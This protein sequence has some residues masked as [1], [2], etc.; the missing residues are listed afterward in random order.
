M[1]LKSMRDTYCDVL[2]EL[3]QEND[4]I[5][6]L[7]ADLSGATGTKRFE[8]SFPDRA[9][10]VGVA[11]ANMIGV[12]AGLSARGKIPFA[13]TFAAFASRRTFDQFFISGNY[14]RLN[15]KLVGSDPGIA[16]GYNGGTHMAFEDIGMMR[17]VPGLVVFEPC[18]NTSLK[19]LVRQSA[20]HN[21]CTYM[22]LHRKDGNIIYDEHE[23]LRLGKGKIIRRGG[24]VTIFALGFIMVPQAMKAAEM[25]EKAGVSATVI[26]IHTIKP[27]DEEL[28]LTQAKATNAVVTC[29]NHQIIGGLGSAVAEV[30]AESGVGKL[31]RIG[32]QDEFGEVGDEPYLMNRFGLTA[33]KICKRIVEFLE[34][35]EPTRRDPEERAELLQRGGLHSDDAIKFRRRR[36]SS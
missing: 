34:S 28:I 9:F 22:R 6:V 36:A 3:A 8:Q 18:D 21:G 24:D 15:I 14:A 7:N 16:A 10:N 29:E 31:K 1:A 25:L 12:A 20:A 35:G 13:S 2:I 5:V 30:L 17:S 32:I 26:D 33:E 11:E 23:E 4:A 27:I 19:A